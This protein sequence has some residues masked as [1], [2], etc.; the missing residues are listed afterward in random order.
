MNI[1]KIIREEVN[2]FVLEQQNKKDIKSFFAHK[3]I[4][5]ENVFKTKFFRSENALKVPKIRIFGH[6]EQF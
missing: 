4:R 2:K 6:F 1:D 5:P 3:Y